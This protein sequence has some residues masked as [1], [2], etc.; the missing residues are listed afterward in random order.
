MTLTANITTGYVDY[1]EF[2]TENESLIF[3]QGKNLNTVEF[4]RD[5]NTLRIIYGD[6]KTFELRDVDFT[7]ATDALVNNIFVAGQADEAT[8]LKTIS[9]DYHIYYTIAN[10][11]TKPENDIYNYRLTAPTENVT[12]TNL[13]DKDLIVVPEGTNVAAAKD[14]N[15]LLINYTYLGNKTVRIKDY[16]FT[17]TQGTDIDTIRIAGTNYQLKSILAPVEYT[18]DDNVEHISSIYNEVITVNNADAKITGYKSIDKIIFNYA[19]SAEVKYTITDNN[20]LQIKYGDKKVTIQN[21]NSDW[22]T[23]IPAVCVKNGDTLNQV[24]VSQETLYISIPYGPSPG[25]YFSGNCCVYDARDL[26]GLGFKNC[27]ISSGEDAWINDITA[28]DNDDVINSYAKVAWRD[29]YIFAGDGADEIH[30]KGGRDKIFVGKKGTGSDDYQRIQEESYGIDNQANAIYF[31]PGED[32]KI[33]DD[34]VY[35]TTYRDRLVFEDFYA[36]N[37]N[38]RFQGWSRRSLSGGDVYYQELQIKDND[39]NLCGTVTIFKKTSS[40]SH[41][42]KFIAKNPQGVLTEYSISTLNKY[43]DVVSTTEDRVVNNDKR[44]YP[45]IMFNIENFDYGKL[46]F[47]RIDRIDEH[48]NLAT[49]LQIKGYNGDHTITLTNYNFNSV[50]DNMNHLEKRLS[51]DTKNISNDYFINYALTDGESYDFTGCQ[52]KMNLALEEGGATLS[53][54]NSKSKLTVGGDKDAVLSMECNVPGGTLT[55]SG[56]DGANNVVIDNF[57]FSSLTNNL[58]TIIVKEGDE[59]VTTKITDNLVVDVNLAGGEYDAS[60]VAYKQLIKGSGTVLNANES[61]TVCIGDDDDYVTTCSGKDITI[62]NDETTVTIKDFFNDDGST[63]Y[64][65]NFCIDNG[66]IYENITLANINHP[67]TS[68]FKGTDCKDVVTLVS[69]LTTDVDIENLSQ[70]T[71]GK[72]VKNEERG[73][74]TY[75][76]DFDNTTVVNL[77]TYAQGKGDKDTITGSAGNDYINGGDGNDSIY[78]GNGNDILIAGGGDDEINGGQGNDTI[79]LQGGNNKIVVNQEIDN[80]RELIIG[81][82]STDT[83]WL[84]EYGSNELIFQ[85]QEE[86]VGEDTYESLFITTNKAGS[87]NGII[88]IRDY[89]NS[90]SRID[91]IVTADTTAENPL[92]IKNHILSDYTIQENGEIYDKSK[93]IYKNREV[94]IILNEGVTDATILNLDKTDNIVLDGNISLSRIYD[95]TEANNNTLIISNGTQTINVVDFNYDGNHSFAINDISIASL[96]INVTASKN[97]S[98]TSYK[99]VIKAVGEIEVEY[100]PETD[101]LLFSGET[102]Y[103]QTGVKKF[104]ISDGNNKV[105]IV[106]D[107]NLNTITP[108][109]V[110]TFDNNTEDNLSQKTLYMTGVSNF[111]AGEGFKFKNVNITGTNGEDLFTGTPNDDVIDGGIGNDIIYNNGGNDVIYTGTGNDEIFLTGGSCQVHING[112]GVKTIHGDT[113]S[114]GHDYLLSTGSAKFINYSNKDTIHFATFD[115]SKIEFARGE[116]D[117]AND[118]LIKSRV[119]GD[120]DAI[121]ISNYFALNE[122]ERISSFNVQGIQYTLEWRESNVKDISAGMYNI[123]TN[124]NPNFVDGIGNMISGENGEAVEIKGRDEF[125]ILMGTSNNDKISAGISGGELYGNAGNDKIYG[126]DKNDYI[127]GGSGNDEIHLGNGEYDRDI[128]SFINTT[129]D[130]S[131][132]FGKDT[133]YNA[134]F[135]DTLKFVHDNGESANPRYIGYKV[136]EL[137]FDK[138]GKTLIIKA[139]G[140]EVKIP[141]YFDKKGKIQSFAVGRVELLNGNN[142]PATYYID[143]LMPSRKLDLSVYGLDELTFIRDITGKKANDLVI[144]KGDEVIETLANF[145]KQKNPIDMVILEDDII[146]IKNSAD[147]QVITGN[148][149]YTGTAYRETITSS[150]SNESYNLKTNKDKII[151]SG[152]FGKDEITLNNNQELSLIFDDVSKVKKAVS[153]KDVILQYE[154]TENQVILKNYAAKEYKNTNIYIIEN[155]KGTYEYNLKY[156]DFDPKTEGNK[157]TGTRLNETYAAAKEDEIINLKTGEDD[158]WYD[159]SDD[160]NGNLIG[161]GNDRITV[162]KNESLGIEIRE[163]YALKKAGQEYIYDIKNEY[164]TKGKDLIIVSTATCSTNPPEGYNKKYN[165]GTITLLGALNIG[166]NTEIYV[167]DDNLSFGYIDYYTGEVKAA[168]RYDESDVSKKGTINGTQLA[169]YINLT[170]YIS[171]KNKGV[172]INTKGGADIVVGSKYNDTIKSMLDDNRIE[173]YGGK[174]KITTGSGGDEIVADGTSSNAINMGNGTNWAWLVS[175]GTNK[176][177]SGKDV[178]IITAANGNNTIKAGNGANLIKLQGG[179]NTVITGKDRDEIVVSD[180]YSTGAQSVNVIKTGSGADTITVDAMSENTV[181]AGNG[182][183]NRYGETIGNKIIL[184]NGINKV[185]SGKNA[186]NIVI[187]GGQNVVSSGAGDDIFNVSGGASIIDGQKGNDIYNIDITEFNS[188]LTIKDTKGKNTLNL[189]KSN[190]NQVNLFFDVSLNKKGKAVYSEIKF[191]TDDAA[192]IGIDGF[193]DFVGVNVANKNVISK[194]EYGDTENDTYKSFTI[195]SAEINKLAADIASWLKSKPKYSSTGDVFALGSAEDVNK[196]VG[197]YTNFA[198]DNYVFDK[199]HSLMS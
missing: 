89:L 102:K 141:N 129:E 103:T 175:S 114:L 88:I 146:S 160:G 54:L 125:D 157:V 39:G 59:T 142:E 30:V 180:P 77:D 3:A 110:G 136:S 164:Q 90:E 174:N 16:N 41:V 7:G 154:G 112:A 80:F 108:A 177:T 24:D 17:K 120:N 23:P 64:A 48:D 139:G 29:T 22:A 185:T 183:K 118:L 169:D 92:A 198:N 170:N 105:K 176:L 116:G 132:A 161:W 67:D 10:D 6:N 56:Y 144:K 72:V 179:K 124:D 40:S 65:G 181:N 150:S 36:K 119:E 145:F 99:E 95:G 123:I 143:E 113:S 167:N 196:L 195:K 117:N 57:D 182:G 32:G 73:K 20:K 158:V 60:A 50:D 84:Q 82:S 45:Y 97:Y 192:N 166:S 122:D 148:K 1:H 155:G 11:F 58:D 63:A 46:T 87:H 85:L 197:A 2:V 140:N 13:S 115:F 18:L 98:G 137:T 53:G 193:D 81:S 5:G 52:Y 47:T 126:S 147:I 25:N 163:K 131:L 61:T 49:D 70:D 35:Y 173:E 91:K 187:T 94:N 152:D 68:Y 31:E 104:E 178:D 168:L 86:F 135:Y 28:T 172:T 19:E 27:N 109:S 4:V 134:N 101:K 74:Y 199:T 96:P 38:L 71:Q 14:V 78:G 44:M 189:G 149:N 33:G 75:I 186:D 159:V 153:G 93:S 26:E 15:D 171:E 37:I 76:S 128:I 188:N 130:N 191:S 83:I 42:D 151:L 156:T 100:N 55:I 34:S 107:T 66:G 51:M 21:Q 9:G 162:N 69:G 138:S 184:N 106:Q 12:L 190:N 79:F 43:F 8:P 194:L 165:L 133:L 127:S 121:V 111:E 62:T